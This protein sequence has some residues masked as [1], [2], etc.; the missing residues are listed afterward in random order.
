[1]RIE[2]T[3]TKWNEERE[4]G[5]ITYNRGT[6]NIF[7]HISA[8]P[9]DGQR[10]Q[11]GEPLSFEIDHS[12]KNRAVNVSRPSDTNIFRSLQNH[13]SKPRKN[14]LPVGLFSIV[15]ILIFVGL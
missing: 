2:G 10:P 8:F 4:F 5:F 14:L 11:L 3:L 7:V 9:R 1:M 6:H 15:V 13:T 12:G